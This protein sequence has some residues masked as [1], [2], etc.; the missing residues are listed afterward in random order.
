MFLKFVEANMLY[1]E[2]PVGVGFSYDSSNS[3]DYEVVT[4][5]ITGI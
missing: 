5:A 2:T 4:N 3:S 1:L